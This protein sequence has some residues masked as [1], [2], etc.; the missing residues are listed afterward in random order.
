MQ[1]QWTEK[2]RPKDLSSVLS[3]NDGSV[4]MLQ[5]MLRQRELH[6]ILVYGPPGCG[7]TT[8]VVSLCNELYPKNR[9]EM[10][11]QL[12]ASDDRGINIIRDDIKS[13]SRILPV[14]YPGELKI[15]LLD[16]AD[17]LTIDAQ[18]ALRRVIEKFAH[19]V[20]FFLICNYLTKLVDAIV[21][22]CHVIEMVH[23]SLSNSLAMQ[24]LIRD[25]EGF[26]ISDEELHSTIARFSNMDMR[27][28][29]NSLH[30]ICISN[31][32]VVDHDSVYR[33]FFHVTRDE[34]EELHKLVLAICDHANKGELNT[35]RMRLYDFL[36]RFHG[37]MIDIYSAITRVCLDAQLYELMAMLSKGE[38]TYIKNGLSFDQLQRMHIVQCVCCN[39]FE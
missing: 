22:R 9:S 24:R 2:Y 15:V 10:L 17:A 1:E 35:N 6:N 4:E 14:S 32:R 12:N 13:F 21:S 33:H 34:Y 16:E 25:R 19:R 38:Y 11:L 7:K 27:G 8:A 39:T 5:H 37:T 20:R 18:F 30:S 36:N 3:N 31:C 28:I 26:T 23:V 29:I